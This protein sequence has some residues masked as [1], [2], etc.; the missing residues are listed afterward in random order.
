VEVG[1]KMWHRGVVGI[2][3]RMTVV[4]VMSSRV[5]EL[6]LPSADKIVTLTSAGT[7]NVAERPNQM[8]PSSD[9]K[10]KEG[11]DK[12][13][14]LVETIETIETIETETQ[15]TFSVQN[16][17]TDKQTKKEQKRRPNLANNKDDL[18]IIVKEQR[19]T[20]K[21]RCYIW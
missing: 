20:G 21:V 9:R 4:V 15:G 3:N 19:N 12:A 2:L 13:D 17:H 8:L 5:D 6:L 18:D 16:I 14:D 10:E 11:K 1:R 7:I